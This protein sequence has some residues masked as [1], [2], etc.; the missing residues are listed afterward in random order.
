[1][2][3]ELGLSTYA[4][5]PKTKPLSFISN[6]CARVGVRV[7]ADFTVFPFFA[8]A[9]RT[10][11]QPDSRKPSHPPGSVCLSCRLRHSGPMPSPLF[12]I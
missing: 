12:K 4:N 9:T 11:E 10:P 5:V 6:V 1:M 7:Y 8:E 3:T 2:L